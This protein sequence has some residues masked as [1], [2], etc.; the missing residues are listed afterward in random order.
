MRIFRGHYGAG[1]VGLAAAAAVV[2]FLVAAAGSD[3]A[4]VRRGSYLVNGTGCNDC[5]TPMKMG[6]SGPEPDAARLLSGHP[7]SLAMPPAPKLPPG[8]W[9]V[10]AAATFTAWAGPWGVSFTANLTPEHET[11]LGEWT[12]QT[13]V[14]TIR[15]GRIM[16]KGR[17]LLPPMPVP[18]MQN[19]TD[20]D[21]RA[22]FAYLQTIPVIKNRVPEPV[23]PGT[24]GMR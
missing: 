10:T 21:L 20:E 3:D 24:S 2:V 11:G 4:A 14:D 5:H 12:A 15:S 16:G 17:A 22:I 7:E 19:L 18:A 8:P 1:V 23:Q 9:L 6:A 13:F